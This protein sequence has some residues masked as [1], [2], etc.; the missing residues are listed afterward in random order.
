MV[1]LEELI[2]QIARSNGPFEIIHVHVAMATLAK[3]LRYEYNILR[4]YLK[5]I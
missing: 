4:V 2:V 1:H 3:T 5:Q